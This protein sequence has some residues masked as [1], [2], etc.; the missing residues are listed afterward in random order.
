MRDQYQRCGEEARRH[1]GRIALASRHSDGLMGKRFGRDAVDHLF[2][3]AGLKAYFH[4]Q[5]RKVSD[6]RA[7]FAHILRRAGEIDLFAA[8]SAELFPLAIPKKRGG[9]RC[10]YRVPI[11]MQLAHCVLKAIVFAAHEISQSQYCWHGRAGHHGCVTAIA[12]HLRRNSGL[13]FVVRGDISGAFSAVSTDVIRNLGIMPEEV[14]E[15]RFNPSNLKIFNPY[16]ERSMES[17]TQRHHRYLDVEEMTEGRGLQGLLEGG[18]SSSALFAMIIDDVNKE[19][20]S[21]FGQLFGYADDFLVVCA[22]SEQ[23]EEAQENLASKLA[24]HH[25]GPFHLR[26]DIYDIQEGFDMLGYNIHRRPCGRLR[27]GPAGPAFDRIFRELSEEVDGI[28]VRFVQPGG[29]GVDG[30]MSRIALNHRI[31][32]IL[33]RYPSMSIFDRLDCRGLLVSQMDFDTIV[34][35]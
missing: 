17:D 29:D 26:T 27:I 10:V 23:A 2:R 8:T 19:W 21:Q 5:R 34:I 33:A 24:T 1:L 15:H 13:R 20:N 4:T 11:E 32:D 22:T 6:K 7:N 14:F 28:E 18:A 30:R 3:H 9:H 12:D 35:G 31:R 16:R 25:A